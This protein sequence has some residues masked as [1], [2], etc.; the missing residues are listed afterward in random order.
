MLA[1]SPLLFFSGMCS[2]ID[3]AVII[4]PSR[5]DSFSI[6]SSDLSFRLL[7]YGSSAKE[8]VGSIGVSVSE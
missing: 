3:I 4:I 6:L 5:A 1:V 8:P 2:G 7:L